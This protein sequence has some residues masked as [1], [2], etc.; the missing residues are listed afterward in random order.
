MDR[1]NFLK[2]ILV[3]FILPKLGDSKEVKRTKLS[4]TVKLPFEEEVRLWVPVPVD[5]DYQ[6]LLSVEA[7]NVK[8]MLETGY[9]GIPA[10]EVFGI[11]VATSSLSKGISSVS[12]DATKAQHCRAEFYLGRW[13]P[14]DPA[15]VRKLILEE[16]LS[17]SDPKVKRVR[18]FLFGNWDA[19]WIAFNS[20]RD[21]SL[22]PPL[23]NGEKV[24]KFMYPL[25]EVNEKLLD[26]YKLT[27]ELQIHYH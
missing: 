24:N 7:G 21:F 9:C 5:T 16:N 10:R 13:V 8:S 11:R 6:R 27:F 25:A 17:L 22:E 23:A 12:R 14:V 2:L 3:A 26:K 4:Y 20:A 19:H 18:E 1:R 15:D